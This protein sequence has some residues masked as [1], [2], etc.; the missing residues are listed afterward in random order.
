[1]PPSAS[2]GKVRCLKQYKKMLCFPWV[3]LAVRLVAVAQQLVTT[4]KNH[5]IFL[6]KFQRILYT[7]R[8]IRSPFFYGFSCY[9]HN[10]ESY[11]NIHYFLKKIT[12]LL[13]ATCFHKYIKYQT[14]CA[15]PSLIN[16]L[17]PSF[18]TKKCNSFISISKI[19]YYLKQCLHSI[20]PKNI[21]CAITSRRP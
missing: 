1:M 17:T 8:T 9:L 2:R 3:A 6:K 15:P 20:I 7:I 18:T 12:C 10:N 4:P 11:F 19:I 13:I 14:N 5:A 21:S 16:Y